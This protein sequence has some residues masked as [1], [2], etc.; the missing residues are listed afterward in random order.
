MERAFPQ[1]QTL[2]D[3]FPDRMDGQPRQ[4]LRRDIHHQHHR[5]RLDGLLVTQELTGGPELLQRPAD[6]SLP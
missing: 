1:P 6:L 2:S 5:A 3:P 4:L